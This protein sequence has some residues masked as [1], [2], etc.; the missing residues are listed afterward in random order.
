MKWLRREEPFSF[1]SPLPSVLFEHHIKSSSSIYPG[2]PLLKAVSSYHVTRREAFTKLFYD[3]MILYNLL[4]EKKD[5]NDQTFHLRGMYF[6]Y[7][8]KC[9]TEFVFI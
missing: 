8:F 2:S 1:S 7:E 3:E 6:L 4:T 5:S 9:I